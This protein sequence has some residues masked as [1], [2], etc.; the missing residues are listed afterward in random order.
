MLAPSSHQIS[1]GAYGSN[2][3]EGDVADLDILVAPLV[4]ELGLTNVLDNVLWQHRVVWRLLNL[5]LAVR[6]ICGIRRAPG[7]M[8]EESSSTRSYQYAGRCSGGGR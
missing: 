2:V 7:N 4:E 8:R 1:Q 5:D 6:H 3:R